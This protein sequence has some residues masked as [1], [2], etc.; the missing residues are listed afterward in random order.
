MTQARPA[1]SEDIGHRERRYLLTMGV[2]IACF[3]VAI[4]MFTQRAGWYT[5]I[6]AVGAVILPYFAVVMANA[7]REPTS[8]RG[9][10]EYQPNLPDR[11]HGPDQPGGPG[12]PGSPG[13]SA[14]S[15]SAGS[16][17]GSADPETHAGHG[18]HA[19][20]RNGAQPPG[21]ADYRQER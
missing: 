15:G 13:G 18:T 16:S 21:G 7:G 3:I 5:A 1:K 17:G 4:I 20:P 19:A 10:R 12:G 9:F 11:F 2:R 6:P 14:S 8:T